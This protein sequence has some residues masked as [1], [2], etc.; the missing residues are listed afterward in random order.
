[1]A[2]GGVVQGEYLSRYTGLLAERV[3]SNSLCLPLA[4]CSIGRSIILTY[5]FF[6]KIKYLTFPG[7]PFENKYDS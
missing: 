1:M 2:C 4:I 5:P 6:I 3:I 7:Y